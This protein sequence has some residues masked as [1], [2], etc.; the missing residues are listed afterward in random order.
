MTNSPSWGEVFWAILMCG[1]KPLLIDA[2]TSKEGTDNL[3][4]QGKA[5]AIIT[6]DN[7]EYD[8]QPNT[9]YLPKPYY[10]YLVAVY[11]SYIGGG[12]GSWNDT[13]IVGTREFRLVN[14][15]LHYQKCRALLYAVNNC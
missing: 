4:A 13:P 11:E 2:R 8:K 10:K 14:A 15:E 6:D 5:V 9:F 12:M 7:F 1:Y 3:I